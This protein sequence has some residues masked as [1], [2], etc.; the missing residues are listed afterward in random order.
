MRTGAAISGVVHGGLLIFAIWGINW[1][2]PEDADPLIVTEIE[3]VDGTDFEAAVST[4]PVVKSEGPADLADPAD[5]QSDP[6]EVDQPDDRTAQADPPLLSQATAPQP[7]PDAPRITFIPPPTDI[8]TEAPKP[9][10][11]VIPSPDPLRD[12]STEP[13]SPASTEPVQPLASVQAPLPQA[14]PVRPPDPR[15]GAGT[16]RAR[17]RARDTGTGTGDA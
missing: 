1:F 4:A 12:Q 5:G 11:A 8:P 6:A 2:S 7:R 3:L 14:K 15:A 16:G 17:S 10:I 9:S 13:E